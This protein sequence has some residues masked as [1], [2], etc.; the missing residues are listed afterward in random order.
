VRV[1]R[2]NA[3]LHGV[4]Q[5]IDLLAGDLFEPLCRSGRFAAIV[6][7]PPY[8]AAGEECAPELAWEPR[9]ALCGG[10]AGFDV[11]DRILSEAPG[12]LDPGGI[13]AM[14]VGLGQAERASRRARDAGFARIEVRP[15]LAG[16]PRVLVAQ[17]VR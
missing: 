9:L 10:A 16:I 17:R 1:A 2:R 3:E 8:L 15:D 7:N 4:A 13:L 14:E 11:I 6:A 12:R 5:R